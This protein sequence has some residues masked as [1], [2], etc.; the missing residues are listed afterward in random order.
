MTRPPDLAERI[1][2][3]ERLLEAIERERRGAAPASAAGDA[4]ANRLRELTYLV[5]RD[6]GSKQLDAADAIALRTLLDQLAALT[7]ELRD[8]A[9]DLNARLDALAADTTRHAADL[10]ALEDSR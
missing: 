7:A 3:L 8:A 6:P 4:P 2:R 9:G 10:R 1:A 5:Q